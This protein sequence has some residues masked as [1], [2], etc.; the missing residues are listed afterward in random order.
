MMKRIMKAGIIGG[1]ILFIWGSALF[2]LFPWHKNLFYSF[3]NE[4][5][6][7]SAIADNAPRSGIYLLPN[8]EKEER[9][10]GRIEAKERM[11]KGPF[12]FASI[13]IHGK[14]P[15]ML[16]SIIE[17]LLLKI[18]VASLVAFL[19]I[20]FSKLSYVN[21]VKWVTLMGTVMGIAASFP[22]AIWFG[23]PP[24]FIFYALV[25]AI[26]GWFLAGIAIAR[27]TGSTE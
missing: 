12:L 8:V 7:L 4:K 16:L 21:G 19:L 11:R 3:T 5:K 22:Y 13:S 27:I 18:V 6:V 23:F 14:D 17:T 26:V 20:R 15:Q 1:L 24:L 2:T 10:S 9:D 25:E